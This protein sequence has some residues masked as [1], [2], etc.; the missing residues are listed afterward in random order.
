VTIRFDKRVVIVTGAGNGLG[1]SH[2]LEFARRGARVVVND[3]GAARDGSGASSEA[4]DAVVQQI[5]DGGGE[6]AANG[7]DVADFSQVEAMVAETVDRWGRVDVLI[8]NAG[9]LRDKT[10]AKMDLQ[11]FQLV[12]DVHV[13][14][15]VNCT[16]AVW[17][18]MREQQYGRIVMTSSSSGIYG[19]FGQ[20]NY[21]AAKMALVGFMN[22]LALEGSKHGIRVNALAPVAATRMTSDLMTKEVLAL[23]E[24]EAVTPAVVFLSSEDAPTRQIVAAGAGVFARVVIQETSGVFLGADR[25]DAEHVAEAWERISDTGGQQELQAGGEQTV[26]FL[27]KAAAELGIRLN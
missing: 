2:A 22:S 26:K 18:V 10:F 16:K 14:G 12:M 5:L 7:A 17:D 8:N 24:P 15:S 19:N 4:A 3:L 27:Q 6:A 9:I 11:D 13:M 25:R 20:T 23:L 21:G 1:R